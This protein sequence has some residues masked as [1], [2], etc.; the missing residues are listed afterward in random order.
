MAMCPEELITYVATSPQLS[1]AK[2]IDTYSFLQE[3]LGN[4]TVLILEYSGT[5]DI[6]IAPHLG[7]HKR[8]LIWR[9]YNIDPTKVRIANQLEMVERFIF[10]AARQYLEVLLEM[11]N[12]EGPNARRRRIVQNSAAPW[13]MAILE[14]MS[15]DASYY[16]NQSAMFETKYWLGETVLLQEVKAFFDQYIAMQEWEA[17]TLTAQFLLTVS[18]VDGE[19]VAKEILPQLR[20]RGSHKLTIKIYARILYERCHRII[21]VQVFNFKVFTGILL[22][23]VEM[24]FG[25]KRLLWNL[26]RR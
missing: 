20:R 22:I 9:D 6:D 25:L 23:G 24:I 1:R 7:R 18:R 13:T 5:G 15:F 4:Q 21:P 2:S 3:L 11:V 12:H 14:K 19:R 8:R 26:D 16:L 17:A 10:S